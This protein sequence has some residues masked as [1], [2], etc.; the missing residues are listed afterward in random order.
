MKKSWTKTPSRRGSIGRNTQRGGP[1]STLEIRK[2]CRKLKGITCGQLFSNMDVDR[3]NS[4]TPREF[5]NGL[6]SVGIHLL[7]IDVQRVFRGIDQDHNGRIS[8]EELQN[9]LFPKSTRVRVTP[10]RD[11]P[12]SARRRAQALDALKYKASIAG[13]K[14]KNE[15]IK[16]DLPTP[17]EEVE[18]EDELNNLQNQ[19]YF[20]ELE[21]ALLRKEAA[22]DGHIEQDDNNNNN[23]RIPNN[24]SS[25]LQTDDIDAQLRHLRDTS[26]RQQQEQK[27]FIS[28]LESETRQLRAE[29]RFTIILSLSLSLKHAHTLNSLDT[30]KCRRCPSQRN[31][32]NTDIG[33]TK[34]IKITKS[35]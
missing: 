8:V 3:G 13:L 22:K 5:Q 26:H 6:K 14:S 7:D 25:L 33:K 18:D 32:K 9:A 35:F 16:L 1:I 27:R 31:R 12:P 29:V 21:C 4:V 23:I 11:S 24:T 28:K 30:D 10:H 20:L 2:L 34:K 19:I 17:K 15:N